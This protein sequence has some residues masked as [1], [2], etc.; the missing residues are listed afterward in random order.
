MI[1][2]TGRDTRVVVKFGS[3]VARNVSEVNWH[4]SQQ[5][6]FQPDGSMIF[7]V[8]ISGLMEIAWWILGYGDQAEVV[9]PTKLRRLVAQRAN[10]MAA[11]YNGTA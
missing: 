10:N 5:I 4:K 9:Q 1:P 11:I 2:E 8:T 3:L 6:E 7:Q